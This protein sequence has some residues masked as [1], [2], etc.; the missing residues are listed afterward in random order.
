MKQE[1]I[2]RE[3]N[4][5]QVRDYWNARPCNIRHSP[6]AVGTREYF[7]EVEARKYFVEPH[8]PAFAE[9]PRWAGKRVLEIGC[10]IGTDTINFARAGARVTAVDLSEKSLELARCRADIF[11]LSDRI[12]FLAAD[13]ERLSDVVPP[14]P[15]DLVYSFG[16]IHHTTHPER[17]VAQVR[18][19]FVHPQSEFKLMVY[20][21]N[22]W[23]VFWILLTEGKGAFW[24]LDE[25]VARYAEAQIGCPVAYTYTPE[26]IRVLLRGFRIKDLFVDH[27]FPYQIREY[28]QYQ[29]VR[30]W[31]FRIMPK[32]VFRAM[33]RRFGWHL[34]VT[35]GP[36]QP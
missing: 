11:G 27:I 18:D 29:Y 21:R 7:D 6:Q 2:F 16:V 30:N 3:K 20:N 13:A 1:E 14:E 19:N 12:T 10:G 25:M 8:I 33:E 22:S 17:V 23:K 34:C 15:Y 26:N 9:F 28:V 24:K 31:Y 5:A 36:E 4:I 35:A 32:P